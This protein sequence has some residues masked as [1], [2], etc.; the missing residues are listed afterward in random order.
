M[1]CGTELVDEA[2]VC[3][4]CGCAAG[5]VGQMVIC[6]SGSGQKSA[7]KKLGWT[8]LKVGLAIVLTVALA[9]GGLWLTIRVFYMNPDG[10]LIQPYALKGAASVLSR[11]ETSYMVAI[12]ENGNGN[13]TKHDLVFSPPTQGQQWF[14]FTVSDDATMCTATAKR[15]LYLFGGFRKGSTITTKYDATSEEFI[16]SS[17]QRDVAMRYIPSFFGGSGDYY[18]SFPDL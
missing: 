7:A 4:K 6:A 17:S 16:H 5:A 1:R 12:I 14:T 13:F 18:P 11:Y 3:T 8:L 15:S 9:I 2:V 10:E